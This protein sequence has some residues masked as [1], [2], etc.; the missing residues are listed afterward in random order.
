[1]EPESVSW[2]SPIEAIRKRPGMYI[3]DPYEGGI[4]HLIYELVANSV[5]LFLSGTATQVGVTINGSEISVGDDGPG[6]PFDQAEMNSV[7]KAEHWLT[8]LHHT[9][10]ADGHAPHVHLNATG[11][12]LAVVNALSSS[13]MVVSHRNGTRWEQRFAKGELVGTPTTSVSSAKGTSIT[14]TADRDVLQASLPRMHVLRRRL[15][16]VAHLF[17][18]MRVQLGDETFCAPGGL[19]DYAQ[20]L[21]SQNEDLCHA[22][23]TPRLLHVRHE[24]DELTVE[25]AA[26][27]SSAKCQW[28]SWCNGTGTRLHGTHVD[29]FRDALRRRG[30]TPAVAMISV[31][32]KEPRFS[33]PMRAKVVNAELR[34]QVRQVVLEALK[35]AGIL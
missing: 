16:D 35:E 6:L 7:S 11:M 23:E 1:M 17:P 12:G 28:L 4:E 32:M 30:W 5:D 21:A 20:F 10:T 34:G 18:G 27:G 14:F 25:A 13:L 19:A 31:I 15:F 2:L 9:P 3:G 22:S 26:T 33:A 24:S 29:G 8:W